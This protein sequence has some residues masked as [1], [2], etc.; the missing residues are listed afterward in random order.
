MVHDAQS[1]A[2]LATTL[3]D[4]ATLTEALGVMRRVATANVLAKGGLRREFTSHDLRES[5]GNKGLAVWERLTAADGSVPLIKT[6]EQKA[7]STP[8]IYQFRHLSFQEALFAKQLVEVGAATWAGWRDD[9]AAVESL[10][11]PSLRNA[12]R[13][14]GNA[15]GNAL[16]RRRDRWDFAGELG[17]GRAVLQALMG[18]L[19]DNVALTDLK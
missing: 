13:I 18:L 7:V 15:L 12:L 10:K 16:G 1:G 8:A 14:G 5:L 17:G 9:K 3:D 6:L 2:L 11:E 19:Q 4:K